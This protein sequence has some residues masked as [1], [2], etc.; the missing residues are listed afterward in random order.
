[1]IDIYNSPKTPSKELRSFEELTC[2]KNPD[3]TG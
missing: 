2:G 3:Q 1:M